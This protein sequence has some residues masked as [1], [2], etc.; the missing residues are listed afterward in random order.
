MPFVDINSLTGK[1]NPAASATPVAANQD[2]GTNNPVPSTTQHQ[3]VNTGN[4]LEIGGIKVITGP[5]FVDDKKEAP[6][7]ATPV[8]LPA[9]PS[10]ATAT[11]PSEVVTISK[12]SD[13]PPIPPQDAVIIEPANALST[14]PN[15]V[16]EN[17]QISPAEKPALPEVNKSEP[18]VV[19]D[20]TGLTGNTTPVVAEPA[21]IEPTIQV[22]TEPQAT[23]VEVVNQSL[24]KL[25]VTPTIETG[26]LDASTLKPQ[27]K[28]DEQNNATEMPPSPVEVSPVSNIDNTVAPVAGLELSELKL[29]NKQYSLDDYL[30]TAV[31]MGASDIH[32]NVG[33][34][35]MARINGSLQQIPS[36]LLTPETTAA[37]AKQLMEYK[38]VPYDENVMDLDMAYELGGISRFR[39]NIHKTQGAFGLVFRLISTQLK[40]VDQLNLPSKIID[41]AKIPYGLVLVTGPT[42]SGKSTTLASIINYINQ[43]QPTHIVTIEDPIEYI[44]PRSKAIVTQR[45]MDRDTESWDDAL[46]SVLRQD[47]NVVLVGEMR[48]FETIAAAIHVAETGHLVFATLHT[49]SASQTIDRIIDVFPEAQQAQIRTQLANSLQAVVS[50][51]LIPL[52]SG[53]G[54]RP[55]V[56]IL[57]A[58]DAVRA[59]VREG[60][61]HQIDNIIQTGADVGMMTMEK[62]LVAM[63]REGLITTERAQEYTDRPD[64]ILS[65][66]S[67]AA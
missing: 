54:M 1:S 18:A 12:L 24:P 34:R 64:E 62:S 66:L 32:F 56:E 33:Y 41:F 46:R 9:M 53:Q 52:S 60:K 39:V 13:L 43:S 16:E 14:T 63:V 25:E 50:Q 4:T 58:T 19:I 42:G 26:V 59:S 10:E 61:V 23:P 29:D 20:A 38:K 27:P 5:D 57:V 49:N 48:D 45:E 47:P 8:D 51:R 21:V 30:K 40:T 3:V 35:A 22:T 31:A 15:S 6:V 36:N 2:A 55:A 44:Y 65:L 28:V 67:K 17:V 7:V 11:T 37:F